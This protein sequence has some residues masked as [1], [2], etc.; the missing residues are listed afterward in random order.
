ML[1]LLLDGPLTA[2]RINERVRLSQSALSQ[3]LGVLRRA[4]LVI[5]RRRSQTAV[6]ALAAGPALGI[7][8]VLYRSYC[9][10]GAVAPQ[11]RAAPAGMHRHR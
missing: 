1:C 6:Y 7:I 2:G 8:E 3:H 11:P 9:A 4:G 10:A 5:R